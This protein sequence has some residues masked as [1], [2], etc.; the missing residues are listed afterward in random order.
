MLF[1]FEEPQYA[2]Y[3]TCRTSRFQETFLKEQG[4]VLNVDTWD[5]LYFCIQKTASD[6]PK[7]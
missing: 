7:Q 6:L 5:C 2:V 4:Q 3:C 1:I